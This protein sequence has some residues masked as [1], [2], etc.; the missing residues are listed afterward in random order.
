[1][2][3][4]KQI[5]ADVSEQDHVSR[6]DTQQTELRQISTDM[7]EK[8]HI[9]RRETQMTE[10]YVQDSSRIKEESSNDVLNGQSNDEKT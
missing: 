5:S 1:M 2:E 7:S 4:I 3:Q 10:L 9:S 6:R 8:E